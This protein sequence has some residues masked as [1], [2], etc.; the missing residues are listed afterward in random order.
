VKEMSMDT[1]WRTIQL[2]IS[3]QGAGVFEVEI[4]TD[5]KDTR[6]TCPVWKKKGSCKHTQYVNI[7]SRV[8]NG[9]YAISVPKGVSEDEVTDAIDDPV[10]FRELILKYSTIEVI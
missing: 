10:R 6:C 3:P 1:T 4:D 9:H 7:K 2:F 5:S 8:N